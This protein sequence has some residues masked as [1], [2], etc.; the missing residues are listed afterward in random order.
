MYGIGPGTVILNRA[1]LGTGV[2]LTG[3]LEETLEGLAEMVI[4]QPLSRLEQIEM[5]L[6]QN[7]DEYGRANFGVQQLPLFN[8]LRPEDVDWLACLS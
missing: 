2:I 4:V 7:F 1:I 5:M 6:C 3:F 8:L